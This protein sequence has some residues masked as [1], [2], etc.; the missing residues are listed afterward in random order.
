MVDLNCIFKSNPGESD[1]LPGLQGSGLPH[2]HPTDGR[3]TP[4]A[5]DHWL[6][7]GWWHSQAQKPRHCP[8]VWASHGLPTRERRCKGRLK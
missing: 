7:A 5:V 4:R 1:D 3:E 2:P 6:A 8:Q